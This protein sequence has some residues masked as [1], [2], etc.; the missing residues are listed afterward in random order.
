VCCAPRIL[1]VRLSCHNIAFQFYW[2]AVVILLLCCNIKCLCVLFFTITFF[3]KGNC[4]LFDQFKRIGLV[5]C[6]IVLSQI[7]AAGRVFYNNLLYCVNL[8]L[9][10]ARQCL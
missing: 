6:H 5:F 7:Y 1:L 8:N 4:K 9:F 3:A 10:L 2:I